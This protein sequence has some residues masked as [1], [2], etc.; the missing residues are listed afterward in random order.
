MKILSEENQGKTLNEICREHET[1]NRYFTIGRV[2]MRIGYLQLSKMK[3]I[4]KELSQNKKI[5]AK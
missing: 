1:A 4:E 5:V 2:N 3:E